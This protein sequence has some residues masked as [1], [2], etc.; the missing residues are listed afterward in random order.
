MN[1]CSCNNSECIEYA[2]RVKKEANYII[3]NGKVFNTA[4]VCEEC[5]QQLVMVEDLKNV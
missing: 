2:K 4:T 5:G 3:L 1:N